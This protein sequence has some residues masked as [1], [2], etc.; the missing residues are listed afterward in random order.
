MV[1]K[2]TDPC[3]IFQLSLV[4]F[5]LCYYNYLFFFWFFFLAIVLDYIRAEPMS[6]L[7]SASQTV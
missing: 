5:L 6:L 2:V 4:S 7:S 1:I 3:I